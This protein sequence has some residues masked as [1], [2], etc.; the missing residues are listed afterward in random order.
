MYV[1]N[2]INNNQTQDHKHHL[3]VR[4]QLNTMIEQLEDT[5][6]QIRISENRHMAIDDTWDRTQLAASST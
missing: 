4:D 6:E 1:I 3:D 2:L 5:I